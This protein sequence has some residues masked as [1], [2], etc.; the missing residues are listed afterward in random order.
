MSTTGRTHDPID[1][2]LRERLR[3]QQI[4][5]CDICNGAHGPILYD[6]D[7][8]HPLA[9]SVDHI[10]PLAR[11]GQKVAD[12]CRATHRVCNRLKSD[13]LPGATPT[14]P[15]P[16]KARTSSPSAPPSSCPP[17][18]CTRCRGTH[19]PRPGITFITARR[20]TT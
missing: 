7:H 15:R 20:W 6:V 9:F 10:V 1:K 18:P 11:G 4:E 14:T 5:H 17:G 12:N 13:A 3:R 2:R 16:S 8:L 19:H